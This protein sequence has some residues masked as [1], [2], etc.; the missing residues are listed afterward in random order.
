M[1]YPDCNGPYRFAP[2]QMVIM[3][4]CSV[5]NLTTAAGTFTWAMMGPLTGNV[6]VAPLAGGPVAIGPAAV[7]AVMP[8]FVATRGA[9]LP[10]TWRFRVTATDPPTTVF[11]GG[12]VL[13]F[14]DSSDAIVEFTEDV[15]SEEPTK[16]ADREEV[17][18]GEY[19]TYSITVP[20]NPD[21][22]QPADATFID[23]IQVEFFD[24]Q[25]GLV[26]QE[27]TCNIGECF[28]D[29]STNDVVWTGSLNPGDIV[30]MSFMILVPEDLLPSEYPEEYL[31]CIQGYDG[32]QEFFDICIST[33]V[34]LPEEPEPPST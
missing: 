17:S 31:N 27:L 20:A 9:N 32:V 2:G 34:E 33:A 15:P 10:S 21:L 1:L 14:P 4:G 8:P 11:P 16:V 23:P 5:T 12:V 30:E 25:G 6:A 29:D 7:V 19:I 26:L 3:F 24:S 22:D 28:Y 18:P 13:G